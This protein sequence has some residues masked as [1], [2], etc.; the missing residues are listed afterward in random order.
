MRHQ[1]MRLQPDASAHPRGRAP[2][3]T[4]GLAVSCVSMLAAFTLL[5]APALAASSLFEPAMFEPAMAGPGMPWSAA[6]E[7]DD[8]GKARMPAV[9]LTDE[10][11]R[12][13]RLQD[14]LAKDHVVVM[15]FIFTTCSTICQPMSA[16]FAQVEK[17]LGTRPVRLVS[18]S[19]DPENDTPARLAEWKARFKGGSAWTL[20][21]GAQEEIDRLRKALGVYTADR[22][23]HTPT[24]VLVDERSGRST[25]LNGL[26]QASDVIA[27]IDTLTKE[28]PAPRRSS[29][30]AV[31]R[32]RPVRPVS[33]QPLSVQAVSVQA[34]SMQ[35]SPQ[36][37]AASPA[38][39][40]EPAAPAVRQDLREGAGKYFQGLSLVD[41]DDRTVRLY[42]DVI[43]GHVVLLHT[44]FASCQGSCPVMTG[45]L[46]ALQ[47]RFADRLG[48]QLRF[49]S[50][51]VDPTNDTPSKLREYAARVQARDGWLF[52]TGSQAAVDAALKKIGQYAVSP[53]GHANVMI[54][55]NEPTGLWKKVFGLSTP[56]AIGDIVQGVL[57]DGAAESAGR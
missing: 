18:I 7:A 2:F 47:K 20:L 31:E 35:S 6:V 36:T 57:D 56:E 37:P 55:G 33:E 40:A 53:E 5:V 48:G 29:G 14:D 16:T 1:P 51:T 13:V 44:F 52:L 34:V 21:T 23:S 8:A 28:A 38:P 32:Q 39:P 46:V 26:V 30:P 54:V 9:V 42:E 3:L 24:T 11:G 12:T 45:T 4:R 50:I 25:R 10:T 15:N 17:R 19:I 41:Q 27:A 43:A 49:V 22:L